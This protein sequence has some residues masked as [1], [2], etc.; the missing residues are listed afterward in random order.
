MTLKLNYKHVQIVE[1][2]WLELIRSGIDDAFG[3]EEGATTQEPT[4]KRAM[5]DTNHSSGDQEHATALQIGAPSI[6]SHSSSDATGAATGAAIA[7]GTTS[8]VVTDGIAGL[9]G[10]S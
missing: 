3:L 2:S 8:N 7:S 9:P 10:C 1:A 5:I 4:S 6:G